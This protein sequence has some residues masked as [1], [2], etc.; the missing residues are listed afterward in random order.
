MIKDFISIDSHFMRILENI[1]KREL[2][3]KGADYDKR[4]IRQENCRN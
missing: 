3:L 2:I 4:R 1:L